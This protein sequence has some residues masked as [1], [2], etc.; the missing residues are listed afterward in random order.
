M[1]WGRVWLPSILVGCN[2]PQPIAHAVLFQE[3][4]RQI[5]QVPT[6]QQAKVGS[7]MR[8]RKYAQDMP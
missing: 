1:R 5:F 2:D 6:L 3:L 7:L 4:F 8:H